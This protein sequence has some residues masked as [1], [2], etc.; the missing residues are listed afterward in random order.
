MHEDGMTGTEDA[1]GRIGTDA[2]R[3][4]KSDADERWEKHGET[5]DYG[6]RPESRGANI[7]Q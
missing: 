6:P 5:D 2:Q 7:R 4:A 1:Q 3:W